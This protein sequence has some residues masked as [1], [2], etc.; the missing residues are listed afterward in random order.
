MGH[1]ETTG[2]ASKRA[3][4]SFVTDKKGATT[5]AGGFGIFEG[6]LSDCA[7]LVEEHLGEE[8]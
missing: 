4:L 7:K 8:G 5:G 6:S 3:N 2:T 1:Q